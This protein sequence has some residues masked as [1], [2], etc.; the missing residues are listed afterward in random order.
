MSNQQAI[1]II[2]DE[3]A[4]RIMLRELF[5]GEGF[6]VI[7]A[8]D[9]KEG[10]AKLRQAGPG[11]ISL[12]VVDLVMPRIGGLAFIRKAR[13]EH[14]EKC[15]LILVCTAHAERKLVEL[16]MQQKVAGYIV[17]PYKMEVMLERA[18]EIMA[19]R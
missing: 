3:P 9:G 4:L 15:P 12:I 2:D 16:A 11:K 6:T 14:E 18:R 7:E 10:L 19:G 13:E 17:K 5:E 1:L 8:N